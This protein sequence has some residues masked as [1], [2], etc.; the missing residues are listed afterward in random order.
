M[1]LCRRS[2]DGDDLLGKCHGAVQ[3]TAVQSIRGCASKIPH[4]TLAEDI[5]RK[6]MLRCSCL[7][8]KPHGSE[9]DKA[10]RTE[11][12]QPTNHKNLAIN[13]IN[14]ILGVLQNLGAAMAL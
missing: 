1:I 13:K 4:D 9:E 14:Q 10:L 12:K 3:F 11:L 6:G 5:L 7:H 8:N 2:G